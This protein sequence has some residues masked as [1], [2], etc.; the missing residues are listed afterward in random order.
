MQ[1]MRSKQR[2]LSLQW[3]GCQIALDE[4]VG[5]HP[6]NQILFANQKTAISPASRRDCKGWSPWCRNFSLGSTSMMCSIHRI[7]HKALRLLQYHA[8]QMFCALQSFQVQLATRVRPSQVTQSF[9]KQF[10]VMQMA[11]IG[12]KKMP[13]STALPMAW[14]HC[15]LSRLALAI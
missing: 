7:W 1:N 2:L 11:L 8:P 12:K 10:Q 13:M 6:T 14:L 15:L 5:L 9:R 4:S 3:E